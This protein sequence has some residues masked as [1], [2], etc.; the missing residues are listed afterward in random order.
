MPSL[1]VVTELLF[2]DVPVDFWCAEFFTRAKQMDVLDE[3]GVL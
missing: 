2:E 3:R 1:K